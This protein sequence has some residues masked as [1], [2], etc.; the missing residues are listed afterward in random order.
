[1]ISLTQLQ[2]GTFGGVVMVPVTVGF[3][4]GDNKGL[5]VSYICNGGRRQGVG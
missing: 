1:M 4:K 3:L 2:D 5:K